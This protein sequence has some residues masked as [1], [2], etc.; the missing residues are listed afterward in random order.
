MTLMMA[1]LEGEN[2]MKINNMKKPITT[3]ESY[4]QSSM[5]PQL[6]LVLTGILSEVL[7]LYR[8]KEFDP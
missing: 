6:N 7:N 3:M 4:F 2:Q 1:T 8:L 5:L